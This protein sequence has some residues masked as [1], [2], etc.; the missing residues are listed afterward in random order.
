MISNKFACV[1]HKMNMINICAALILYIYRLVVTISLQS[2]Y[3]INLLMK[4]TLRFRFFLNELKL[5]ESL[6]PSGIWL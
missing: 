2:A 4:G 5:G 6:I 1:K 3:Q